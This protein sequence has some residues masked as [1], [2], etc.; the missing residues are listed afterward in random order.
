[1][2]TGTIEDLPNGIVINVEAKVD[3]KCKTSLLNTSNVN[4]YFIMNFA[5]G[6]CTLGYFQN[7]SKQWQHNATF[8]IRDSKGG[9]QYFQN[10]MWKLF[11]HSIQESYAQYVLENET[12]K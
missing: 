1:M 9:L 3:L 4:G 6:V 8:P 5:F 2:S 11:E 7:N 10:N 12:L